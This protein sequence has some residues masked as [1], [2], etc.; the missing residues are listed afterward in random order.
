MEVL[1]RDVGMIWGISCSQCSEM[2][3]WKLDGG[4]YGIYIVNDT[5]AFIRIPRVNLYC[6]MRGETDGMDTHFIE[7]NKTQLW[8]W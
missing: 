3:Q 2:R 5:K 1:L 6:A 7:E 4:G 8:G